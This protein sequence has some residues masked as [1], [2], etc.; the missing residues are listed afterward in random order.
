M[1]KFE[2]YTVVVEINWDANNYDTF[3]PIA[4]SEKKAKEEALK[5]A[6][7]KHKTKL[8]KIISCSNK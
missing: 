7:K 1:A 5:L 2:T 3:Y 6:E 8:L 4:K